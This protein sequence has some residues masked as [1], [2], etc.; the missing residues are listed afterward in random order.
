VLK[1]GKEGS[2]GT[3][4]HGQTDRQTDSVK[5]VVEG[6]PHMNIEGSWYQCH[7]ANYTNKERFALREHSVD[8]A[9]SRSRYLM[10][11]VVAI[12]SRQ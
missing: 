7:Y 4:T 2:T 12:S 11:V 3:C 9:F 1:E 10:T 5:Y 8:A 6:R